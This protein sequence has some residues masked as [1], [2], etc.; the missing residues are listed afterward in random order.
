ME[1]S[2]PPPSPQMQQARAK[3]VLAAPGILKT[4]QAL[5]PS[6]WLLDG[7]HG[8]MGLCMCVCVRA[9]RVCVVC[10]R[11]CCRAALDMQRT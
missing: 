2:R 8:R 3:G 11:G 6:L 4:L 1:L 9:L 5:L 7:K 10:R